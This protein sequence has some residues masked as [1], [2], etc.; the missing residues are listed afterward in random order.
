MTC[1]V[2]LTLFRFAS[3]VTIDFL[4]V[5]ALL[6]FEIMVKCET[7][8]KDKSH[9]MPGHNNNIDNNQ[10]LRHCREITDC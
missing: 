8:N 9:I 7:F 10:L 1:T 6:K 2:D 3:C 4:L 5:V